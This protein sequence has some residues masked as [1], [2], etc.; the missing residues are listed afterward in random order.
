[1]NPGVLFAKS[2]NPTCVPYYR[3]GPILQ[4]VEKYSWILNTGISLL[5]LC[6]INIFYYQGNGWIYTRQTLKSPCLGTGGKKMKDFVTK[7][8]QKRCPL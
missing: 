5:N 8:N 7:T 1:M 2:G 4:V 3:N 6:Y